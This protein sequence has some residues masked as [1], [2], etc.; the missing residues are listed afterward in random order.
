MLE[1]LA[2]VVMFMGV[3]LFSALMIMGSYAATEESSWRKRKMRE[4]T[5]DYYGNKLDE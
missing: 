4:G 5:H 3:A 2:G 1:F